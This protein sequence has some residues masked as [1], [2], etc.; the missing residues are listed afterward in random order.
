VIQNCN[1]ENKKQCCFETMIKSVVP[2]RSIHSPFLIGTE[3]LK[4]ASKIVIKEIWITSFRYWGELGIWS[5]GMASKDLY[6]R[7]NWFGIEDWLFCCCFNSTTNLNTR[8]RLDKEFQFNLPS[9]SACKK[10]IYQCRLV[11]FV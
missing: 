1:H 10:S 8:S 11:Y 6:W 4:C 9:S 5:C 3:D 2:L 7:P